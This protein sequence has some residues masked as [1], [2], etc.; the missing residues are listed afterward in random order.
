MRRIPRARL[1]VFALA[2]LV[3]T[4]N[5]LIAE[6]PKGLSDQAGLDVNGLKRAGRI[7]QEA[8]NH[9]QIAGAVLLVA[10]KG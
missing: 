3:L 6:Q 5:L 10:Q 9:K 4:P 7:F 2:L 1:S 8:V